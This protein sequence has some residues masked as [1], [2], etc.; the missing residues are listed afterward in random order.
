M[1]NKYTVIWEWLATALLILCV[2]LTSLNMYPWNV[3][4]GFAGNFA[5]TVVGIY[6]QKFSLIT[7]S[8]VLTLMYLGG[9]WLYITKVF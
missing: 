1:N 4:A 6:W 7:I 8:V 3:F 5:W 2:G 9:I